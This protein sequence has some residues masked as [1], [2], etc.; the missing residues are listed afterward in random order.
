MSQTEDFKEKF[1]K[2][3]WDTDLKKLMFWVRIGVIVC[4]L[5]S[6]VLNSVTGWAVQ[7]T[8][9]SCIEDQG[10]I[11]F[12]S[13][14]GYF[15]TNA[16]FASGLVLLNT[17]LC[18]FLFACFS[19]RFIFW[20]TSLRPAVFFLIFLTLSAFTRQFFWT[21]VPEGSCWTESILPSLILPQTGSPDFFFSSIAGILLFFILEN[22]LVKNWVLFALSVTALCSVS[23]SI[24]ILRRDYTVSLITG[25]AMG[26][27]IWIISDPISKSLESWT[28]SSNTEANFSIQ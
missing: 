5:I 24:L 22:K 26:H 6:G 13:L 14:N 28:G 8:E 18:D 7:K 10:F 23:I 19:M 21:K 25:L 11:I 12:N 1:S 15:C 17:L 9:V 3:N 16:E 4:L 2:N 20:R 27:Y